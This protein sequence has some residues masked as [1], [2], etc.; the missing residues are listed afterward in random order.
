MNC[1]PFTALNCPCGRCNIL[2]GIVQ[3]SDQFGSGVMTTDGLDAGLIATVLESP[4]IV[5][6]LTVFGWVEGQ[7][8]LGICDL[9]K[10]PVE[11]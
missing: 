4:T 9:N 10:V 11:I 6:D 7:F 1:V 8:S 3:R 5:D 2:V